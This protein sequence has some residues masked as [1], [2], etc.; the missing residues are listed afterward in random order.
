[1]RP[2]AA[3]SATEAFPSTASHV[4]VALNTREANISKFCQKTVKFISH[5]EKLKCF[6][7]ATSRFSEGIK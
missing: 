4:K 6:I 2:R 7:Y 5:L 1:M 3:L